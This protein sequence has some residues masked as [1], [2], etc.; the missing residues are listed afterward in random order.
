VPPPGTGSNLNKMPLTAEST[1]THFDFLFLDLGLRLTVNRHIPV[2][3]SRITFNCYIDIFECRLELCH[4]T[5]LHFLN[6]IRK[7]TVTNAV[8][9]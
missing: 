9:G 5:N 3:R 4:S 6:S 7:I 1:K 2:S 8:I